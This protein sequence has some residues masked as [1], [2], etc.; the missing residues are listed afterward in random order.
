MG[1]GNAAVSVGIPWESE[2]D[3]CWSWDLTWSWYQRRTERCRTG[4]A[5][6]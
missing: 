4:I 1:K 3:G 2:I 5:E 6:T